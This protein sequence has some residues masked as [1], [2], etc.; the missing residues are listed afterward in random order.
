MARHANLPDQLILPDPDNNLETV[1][2][3]NPIAGTYVV[4]V[5][6]GNLL[7]PPQDFALVLTGADIS[8]RTE[9]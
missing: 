1:P 3:E 4:Q 8:T 5:F 9:T 2:L 7:K 6:V